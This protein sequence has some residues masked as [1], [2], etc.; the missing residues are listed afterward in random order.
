MHRKG[1]AP[2]PADNEAKWGTQE[3]APEGPRSKPNARRRV[4]GEGISRP[5][6]QDLAME[7]YA[8]I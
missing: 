3:Y 8:E 1:Q 5:P 6:R 2:K 4:G 7:Y